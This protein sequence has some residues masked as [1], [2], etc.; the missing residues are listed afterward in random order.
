MP[1]VPPDPPAATPEFLALSPE[2]DEAPLDPLAR[3][4]Q[5]ITA[6]LGGDESR[7]ARKN[8]KLP[9]QLAGL[10]FLRAQG[11]DNREIADRLGVGQQTLR[12]LIAKA[13]REYGWDDLGSKL[14]D[15]ALPIAV[16]N[17]IKHLD[18]EGT[19]EAVAS[20]QHT[21]TRTVA[22]GLGALK[23]HAAVKSEIKK[24]EI[25]VLRVEFAGVPQLPPG[26]GSR[27]VE[28]S[29]MA[30]PRRALLDG[31]GLPSAAPIDAEIVHQE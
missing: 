10:V 17:V 23:T 24:T 11:F 27:L 14:A 18:Q 13:R 12:K 25:Q 8:K 16:D 31:A 20:G 30:A 28:G 29:V 7:D 19:P 26:G 6:D 9:R 2:P 3:I 4:G 21:M 1:L 5:D 22:A 15:V